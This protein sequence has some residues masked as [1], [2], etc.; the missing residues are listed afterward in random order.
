MRILLMRWLHL[1]P[2]EFDK[3][4]NPHNC[5]MFNLVMRSDEKYRLEKPFPTRATP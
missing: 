1:S 4:R 5:E 2:E 3:M